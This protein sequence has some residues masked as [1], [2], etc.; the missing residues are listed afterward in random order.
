M[1]AE[2]S[3][4]LIEVFPEP[5]LPMRRT[6]FFMLVDFKGTIGLRKLRA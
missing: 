4:H 1:V 3:I 2:S 6:F 5:D